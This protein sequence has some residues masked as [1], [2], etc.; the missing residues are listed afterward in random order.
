MQLIDYIIPTGVRGFVV[1]G[2]L[3]AVMSTADS[4]LNITSITLIKDFIQPIFKINNQNRM[5]L[6]A[7][8]INILVG[9]LAI[10]TALQFEHVTDLVIFISGFWGP[11]ILVPLILALFNYII[12]KKAFII[13][14][15]A[16]AIG[17]ILWESIYATTTSVRGVFVGTIINFFCFI[18]FYTINTNRNT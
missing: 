11:V 1:I 15:F 9:S 13:S 17:F 12:S 8:V 3:A 16:G 14:C 4:D 18:L 10:I 5:L 2:L 7:R 6:L